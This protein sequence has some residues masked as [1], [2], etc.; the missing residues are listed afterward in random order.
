MKSLS[1]VLAAFLGVAACAAR[2]L[3]SDRDA[4]GGGTGDVGTTEADA[5]DAGTSDAGTSDAGINNDG[6][7]DDAVTHPPPCDGM[8]HLRVAAAFVGGGPVARGSR[9]RTE[10]GYALF[11]VDG[12]CT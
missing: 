4:H 10:N 9:V 7:S 3:G 5:D 6:T 2:Q 12:N 11:A 8:P 1:P